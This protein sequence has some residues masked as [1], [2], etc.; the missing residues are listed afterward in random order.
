[1]SSCGAKDIGWTLWTWGLVRRVVIR[2]SAREQT[3]ADQGMDK[4]GQGWS[5]S[6]ISRHEVRRPRR[7][8]PRPM[9]ATKAPPAADITPLPRPPLGLA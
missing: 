2:K 7:L 5:I 1:M 8:S 4:D 6:P 9:A 3:A